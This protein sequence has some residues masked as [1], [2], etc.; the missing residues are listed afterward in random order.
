MGKAAGWD[1]GRIVCK[2]EDRAAIKAMGRAVGK[3][4]AGLQAGLST[5]L[6]EIST[7]T[8]DQSYELAVLK[9]EFGRTAF[10]ICY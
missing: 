2:A 5:G 10:C 6:Q 7:L 9:C 4:R 8:S 1:S 3:N